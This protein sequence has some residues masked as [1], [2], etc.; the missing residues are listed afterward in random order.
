MSVS[1]ANAVVV[2]NDAD[3]V[4]RALQCDLNDISY[5]KTRAISKLATFCAVEK[6]AGQVDGSFTGSGQWNDDADRIDEV[7]DGLMRDADPHL[8]QYGPAGSG[9]GEVLYSGLAY[10]INYEIREAA[11]GVVE[12][13]YAF[14]VTGND[15][16]TVWPA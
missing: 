8:Y 3:D 6:A 5:I 13:S 1:S 14:E 7:M 4:A 12:V 2:I 11:E 15:V 10:L 9:A 16:R